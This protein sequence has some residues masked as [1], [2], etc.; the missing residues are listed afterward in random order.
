MKKVLVSAILGASAMAGCA[1]VPVQIH[2]P[3]DNVVYVLDRQ[4]GYFQ[5][6]P[7]GRVMRCS[8]PNQCVQ[9]YAGE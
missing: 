3:S 6:V 8:A 9:V 7:A 1:W 5:F 4:V 2:A